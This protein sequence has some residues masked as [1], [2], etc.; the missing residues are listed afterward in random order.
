M[1]GQA[2]YDG[3][4]RL[5]A[6]V[7]S[8]LRV[9]SKMTEGQNSFLQSLFCD[10]YRFM[11]NESHEPF[12]SK[13]VRGTDGAAYP[14]SST[15]VLP[16]I[17][18]DGWT[19]EKMAKLLKGHKVEEVEDPSN[20]PPSCGLRDDEPEPLDLTDRCWWDEVDDIWLTDFPPPP[21]F[22]AYESR[23]YDEED[24]DERH[25]RACTPEEVA[26]LEADHARARAVERVEEEEL[27]DAWFE[28]LRQEAS[29]D[30]RP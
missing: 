29:S 4:G 21:G 30:K 24:E 25:V 28:M 3:L 8:C 18:H 7:P 9:G 17:R 14:H 11:T 19:G 27:R 13:S 20:R 15:P 12:A 23:P 26:V 6:F 2:R 16:A 5:R 22:T 1:P 10:P